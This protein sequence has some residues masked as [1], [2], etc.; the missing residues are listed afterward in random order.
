MQPPRKIRS[1]RSPSTLIRMT[2]RTAGTGLVAGAVAGRGGFA[3]VV[4]PA[5]GVARTTFGEVFGCSQAVP[6]KPSSSTAD[7]GKLRNRK[8]FVFATVRFYA[9]AWSAS[10]VDDQ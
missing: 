7:H 9:A 1:G 5:G 2:R 6:A 4:P 8:R 3:A 10:K